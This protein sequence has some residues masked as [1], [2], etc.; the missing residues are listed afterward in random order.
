MDYKKRIETLE[1]ANAITGAMAALVQV[2]RAGDVSCFP[3]SSAPLLH[4]CGEVCSPNLL[5]SIGGHS[6]RR[7]R[8]NGTTHCANGAGRKPRCEGSVCGRYFAF[9]R[10]KIG[11]YITSLRRGA[12]LARGI[13]MENADV[14]LVDIAGR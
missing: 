12:V 11:R 5:V 7:K 1:G 9:A 3:I 8:Y 4:A 14:A 2:V 13:V 6:C 10:A